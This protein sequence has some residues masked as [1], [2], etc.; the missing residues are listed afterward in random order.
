MTQHLSI[1]ITWK[2]NGYIGLVCNKLCYNNAFLRLKNI[3]GSRN[4]EAEEKLAG[5]PIAGHEP[6]I[7]CL[8]EDGCFMSETVYTKTTVHPYKKRSLPCDK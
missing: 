3:A 5:C 4:D 8:S 2:D 1:R 7:P 6:E